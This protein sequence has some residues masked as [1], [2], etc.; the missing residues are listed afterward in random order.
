MILQ[1]RVIEH[2]PERD[3]DPP[4]PNRIALHQNYPNP[5]N[6]GT[7]IAFELKYSLPVTLELFNIL[8]QHIRTLASGKIL[9]AGGNSIEWDGRNQKGNAVA[10]GV[11]FYRLT[12]G[13]QTATKK[14][15]LLK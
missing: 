7:T 4:L 5:F 1:R 10:S 15:L 14:M 6:E 3:P 13:N 12:A 8:G 2:K 9:S 11:Y